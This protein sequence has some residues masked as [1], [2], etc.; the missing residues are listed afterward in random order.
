M[1][2]L[3]CLLSALLLSGC[4]AGGHGTLEGSATNV[5][6][7]QP[8]RLQD[9]KNLKLEWVGNNKRETNEWVWKTSSP[10]A[11]LKS[12]YKTERPGAKVV[13]SGD[14]TTYTWTG[15]TSCRAHPA[16]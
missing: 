4:S 13:Q 5:P 1:R 16:A 11:D 12:F 9:F 6:L 7:F 8:A 15:C 10:T 14:R 2:R 3:L